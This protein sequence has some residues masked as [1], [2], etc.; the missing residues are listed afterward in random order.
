LLQNNLLEINLE[1]LEKKIS[2]IQNK[3]SLLVLCFII[4]AFGWNPKTVLTGDVAS[5]P[6]YRIPYKTMKVLYYKINNN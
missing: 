3:K 5:F 1:K 6:G 2:F 4:Y